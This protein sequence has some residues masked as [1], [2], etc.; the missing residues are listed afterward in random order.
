M[1]RKTMR[2]YNK[3]TKRYKKTI[4]RKYKGGLTPRKSTL[5]KLRH[6]KQQRD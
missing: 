3:V 5:K 6:T 1:A 4:K 2:K